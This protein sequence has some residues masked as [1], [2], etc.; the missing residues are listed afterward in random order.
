MAT[1]KLGSFFALDDHETLP[2]LRGKREIQGIR[3]SQASTILLSQHIPKRVHQGLILR[4]RMDGKGAH[5]LKERFAMA[6]VELPHEG[7]ILVSERC[8]NSLT[9]LQQ[10]RMSSLFY[11]NFAQMFAC[12]GI[13]LITVLH[14]CFHQVSEYRE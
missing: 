2:C 10:L 7:L 1:S 4:R 8:G 12:G 5:Q 9:L 13:V 14:R 6:R 3:K 11:Q